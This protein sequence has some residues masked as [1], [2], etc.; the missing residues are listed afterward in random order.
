MNKLADLLD[1]AQRTNPSIAINRVEQKM[2]VKKGTFLRVK[3]N[4][5]L[6]SPKNAKIVADWIGKKTNDECLELLQN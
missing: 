4:G 1:A 5:T 6:L 3:N 2:G